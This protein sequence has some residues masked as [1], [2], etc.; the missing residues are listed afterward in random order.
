M[1][2]NPEQYVTPGCGE[3]LTPEEQIAIGRE[4]REALAAGDTARAE[5]ARDRLVLACWLH[6]RNIAV[7][8]SRGVYDPEDATSNAMV[9]LFNAAYQYDPERGL[10]F[11]TFADHWLRCGVGRYARAQHYLV[12][13]PDSVH[14]LNHRA[15]HPDKKESLTESQ[16]GLLRHAVS[17]IKPAIRDGDNNHYNKPGMEDIKMSISRIE[18]HRAGP[19]ANA[20]F[21]DDF[22]V[23]MSAIKK[24]EPR[25]QTAI[26]MT[27]GI[28][29]EPATL[30]EIARAI[31]VTGERARQIRDRAV[32]R[33][34]TMLVGRPSVPRWLKQQ[35]ESREKWRA[36]RRA[37]RESERQALAS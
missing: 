15:N 20:E 4:M 31:D 18:D 22:R 16:I 35:R 33:L 19:E 24:L 7:R 5:A 6:A 21:R 27:Y 11:T 17:A 30:R 9:Y 32:E 2:P 3:T 14:M 8:A 10:A 36:E 25:D 34:R 28:D 23:A 13:I 37:R 12:R 29:C 26:R 1:I